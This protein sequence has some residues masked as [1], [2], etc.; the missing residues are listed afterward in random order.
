[1]ELL[2][3]HRFEAKVQRCQGKGY[4]VKGDMLYYGK[5]P[6]AQ[7]V[8]VPTASNNKTTTSDNVYKTKRLIAR[9]YGI[10]VGKV[11]PADKV[12]DAIYL[13]QA[14]NREAIVKECA[15]F[16]N[17]TPEAV[18]DY[19]P[20]ENWPVSN[21]FFKFSEIR[22]HEIGVWCLVYFISAGLSYLFHPLLT[23]ILAVALFLLCLLFV[24]IQCLAGLFLA[25]MGITDFGLFFP[26]LMDI[27]DIIAPYR[28]ISSILSAIVV[29]IVLMVSKSK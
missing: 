22:F 6:I 18:I 29:T 1:M 12:S 8:G 17:G 15:L 2:T 27:V 16:V 25:C 11:I 4:R 20:K 26:D 3:P 23:A 21:N 13:H 5:F 10:S 9:K 28:Y 7:R 14:N 24:I 19:G